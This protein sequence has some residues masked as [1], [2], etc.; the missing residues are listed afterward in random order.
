M[1]RFYGYK[2]WTLEEHPR[3]FYVGKGTKG[4]PTSKHR[5]HKWHAI[6]ERF[7][8]RV[9]ICIGPSTNE[10]ACIWEIENIAKEHTFSLNHH[11]HADDIGC[12]FTTGGD[13]GTPGVKRPDLSIRNSTNR[14]KPSPLKGRKLS[15]EHRKAISD[16]SRG[17]TPW[18]KGKKCPYISECKKGKKRPDLSE[19][20]HA[21]KGKKCSPESI[22]KRIKSAT[23]KKRGPYKRKKDVLLP[24]KPQGLQS[25]PFQVIPASASHFLH[26]PVRGSPAQQKWIGPNERKQCGPSYQACPIPN[27]KFSMRLVTSI[28]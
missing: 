15:P 16:K 19:R 1:Y 26:R 5:N 8:L 11:H 25:P 17:R 12:N 2:H 22:A 18:N 13:T 14:G 28:V 20:N 4:R 9:E 27:E 3:C 10:E 21:N 6:V 24:W 7:G 23:G